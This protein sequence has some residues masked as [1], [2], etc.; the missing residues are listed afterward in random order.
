MDLRRALGAS[1]H[2]PLRLDSDVGCQVRYAG[3]CGFQLET[4]E[5]EKAQNH[6]S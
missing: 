4:G 1:Q 6:C 5:K 2:A 3:M